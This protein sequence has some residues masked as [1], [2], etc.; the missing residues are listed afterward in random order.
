MRH[1]DD[2]ERTFFRSPT[3]I[4]HQNGG[5]YFASREGEHGP[6]PREAVAQREA[7]RYAR[8]CA[9]WRSYEEARRVNPGVL[10]PRR[11]SANEVR[12]GAP[13]LR[14]WGRV[15]FR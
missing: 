10:V 6:Y 2:S 5:W 11:R 12:P 3:R 4:I 13:R 8:D 9:S 1:T 7:S 15:A 14:S